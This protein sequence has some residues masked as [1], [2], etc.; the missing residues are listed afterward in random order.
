MRRLPVYILIDTSAS[1]RGEPIE[2]VKAGLQSILYSL[3]Q[4]PDALERVCLSIISYHSHAEQVLPLTEVY[5][6]ILPEI[7]TAVEIL[8]VKIPPEIGIGPTSA[9]VYAGLTKTLAHE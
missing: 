8:P 3:R 5:K 1:M 7:E 4:D 9:E 2:A 6:V